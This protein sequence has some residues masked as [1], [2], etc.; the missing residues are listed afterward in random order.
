MLPGGLTTRRFF[1]LAAVKATAHLDRLPSCR[2]C[3]QTTTGTSER[4]PTTNQIIVLI[5][6]EGDGKGMTP[7]SAIF[8]MVIKSGSSLMAKQKATRQT[9]MKGKKGQIGV[10][11]VLIT[12]SFKAII[13][14]R[15][16]YCNK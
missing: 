10:L 12:L 15:L 11:L 1:R 7:A 13:L 16:I 14:L 5:R 4:P 8:E 2:K 3:H 9:R 6:S